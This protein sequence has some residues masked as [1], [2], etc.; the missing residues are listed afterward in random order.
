MSHEEILAVPDH[1]FGTLNLEDLEGDLF[2]IR[3]NIL[4]TRRVRRL[5][6]NENTPLAEPTRRVNSLAL[7]LFNNI[8]NF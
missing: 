4:S 7:R 5:N 8:P 6:L 1:Q 2:V 3:Q